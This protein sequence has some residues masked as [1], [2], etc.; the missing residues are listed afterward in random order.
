MFF[1]FRDIWNHFD[2]DNGRTNNN[3]EGFHSK[4][5]KRAC[6]PHQNIYS[7]IE[8]IRNL[9]MENEGT[10]KM[11]LTGSATAPKSKTIYKRINKR[12]ISLK[13]KFLSNAITLMSYVDD[14]GDLLHLE[15]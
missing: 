12:L 6:H 14:V 5:N 9:Q 11:L 7:F 3:V 10:M 13:N 1:I 4:L 15:N 2:N 8:L